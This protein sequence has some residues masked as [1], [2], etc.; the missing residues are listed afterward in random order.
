MDVWLLAGSVSTALFAAANVPMLAKAVRTRD[1]SSYSLSSL[2]VSNVANVIHTVYVVSLPWGPIW[3]LHGFYLITMAAM[4]TLYLAGAKHPSALPGE[5]R[6]HGVSMS[7]ARDA[8]SDRTR[9]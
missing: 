4:A 2:M 3:V 5:P 7:H 9:P 1:L 8:G 6:L